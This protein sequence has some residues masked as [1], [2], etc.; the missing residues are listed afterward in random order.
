MK[1][2]LLLSIIVGVFVLA[3]CIET[4]SGCTSDNDCQDWQTCNLSSKLCQTDPGFCGSDTDCNSTLLECDTN[5][6]HTCVYKSGRCLS[7]MNCEKWQVCSTSDSRGLCS[8]RQRAFEIRFISPYVS[9][10]RKTGYY[11]NADRSRFF[12]RLSKNSDLY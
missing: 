5:N 11:S 9:S 10:S 4:E 6:T 7:D 2:I 1:N 3:G 12:R 8:K